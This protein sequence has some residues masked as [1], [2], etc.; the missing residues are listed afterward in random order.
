MNFLIRS[1]HPAVQEVSSD[2]DPENQ[3]SVPTIPKPTATLE[4]LIAE[5][6]S[7]ESKGDDADKDSDGVGDAGSLAP[8]STLKNQGNHIDVSEDDGWI[9]IPYKELPDNWADAADILEL[10]SLDRSFI[11]PGEQM[12]ILV[13]L[14]ASKQESEIITPF[15]VA[16]ALSRNGKSTQNNTQDIETLNIT[17]GPVSPSRVVSSITEGISR[18]RLE[19]NSENISSAN[20]LSTEDDISATASLLRR[21]CHKQQTEII[22]ESFRNSYFFV[23]I[24]E[25]DEQLWSKKS[26]ASSMNSAVGRERNHSSG[27]SKRIPRSNVVSAVIDKSRFDGNTSGGMARDTTKCCSLSNG[28]I[29]VLLEVKTGVSNLKDPVLEVIQFE[30]YQSSNS[31]FKNHKNLLDSDHEDPCQELLDWLLPLDRATSSSRPLSPPLT[32]SLSQKLTSGSG[33]QIFSFTHFRSYSMPSLPQVNGPPPFSN[34]KP[35]LDPEDYDRYSSEKLIKS[36]DTG[37]EGLLSFRGISL[38]PQRFSADCGL[39]GLYLPGRRWRRKLEIIHPVEIC[40][41][42]T[43]CNTEDMLC[44]QIKNVSPA[45]TPDIVIFVDAITL[46]CEEESKGGPRLSLPITSIETGNGHCLPDLALRTGEEHSYIL[47]L[48]T[49]ATKDHK[50]NSE[51]IPYARAG[52]AAPNTMMPSTSGGMISF[53]TVNQFAILVSC[54]C[55]YTESKLFF[56]HLIDWRPH[57]ASDLMVS[58]ASESHKLTHSLNVRELGLPVKVLTLKATNLTSEDLTFT[59]L[60]PETPVSPFLSLNSTPKTPMNMH[61][62]FHDNAGRNR[63]K[64]ENS[65]YMPL[66]DVKVSSC[67]GK[68]SAIMSDVTSSNSS[69]LTHLWLQSAVPLGCIPGHSSATVKLELLPLTDGIIDL[70]TLHIAIK[71][72]GVTYIPEQPVK[73]HAISSTADGIL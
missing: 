68:Q 11:F 64:S 23:R 67:I 61:S 26:A 43:E 9:T 69:G 37:N 7:A 1:A 21:E 48:A 41:F 5:D 38:E 13:C 20:T 45:H 2:V 59:V 54:R 28:D 57:I 17:S 62:V 56:K 8:G 30:K 70:D 35:A 66:D 53:S 63:D 12:H 42:A 44:V 22:L 16:A 60:S 33:S 4:G 32:S 50:R 25:A 36:K 47:K 52:L 31:G 24:T 19:N 3:K 39:E 10:R 65:V 46:V 29:V 18:Q 72:K 27:G 40:S 15:T 58:I 49:R 51:M 73:V 71:E 6:P 14:S 55:N 34:P